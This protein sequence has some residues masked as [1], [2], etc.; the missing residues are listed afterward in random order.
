MVGGGDF[1]NPPVPFLRGGNERRWK[2][3]IDFM[4]KKAEEI[5]DGKYDE[6]QG[7]SPRVSGLLELPGTVVTSW[8]KRLSERGVHKL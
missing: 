7:P 6:G 8:I 3:N 4:M 2:A 1:Q 5:R